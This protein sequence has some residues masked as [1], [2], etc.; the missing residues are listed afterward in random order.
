MKRK[1]VCISVSGMKNCNGSFQWKFLFEEKDGLS[2]SEDYVALTEKDSDTFIIGS[3]Y[4]L[5]LIGPA[6][7]SPNMDERF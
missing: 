4:Y 7:E 2:G 3:T 6:S 5:D 1:F